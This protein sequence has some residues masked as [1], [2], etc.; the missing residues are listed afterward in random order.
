MIENLPQDH[1]G[2]KARCCNTCGRLT[3]PEG[4]HII[5]QKSM[6]CGYQ[7][8]KTCRICEKERKLRGH[9]KLTYGLEYETYLE[10][11]EEQNGRCYL[12]GNPPSGKSERLVVDHNHRT[13]EVRKL[14]CVT[15]NVQLAKFESDP[16]FI[17]KIANY[18]NMGLSPTLP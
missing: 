13:G 16:T 8:Y 6:S 15:C 5:P 10:M 7:V 12:C 2:R 9:L 18:L 4:F 17:F 3:Q 1:Y 14:L 11:V